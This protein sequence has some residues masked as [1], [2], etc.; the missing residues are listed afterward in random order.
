MEPKLFLLAVTFGKENLC[1]D[2]NGEI[3]DYSNSHLLKSQ[4]CH[5]Q[6]RRQWR[7][8]TVCGVFLFVYENPILFVE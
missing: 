6:D 2:G 1:V 8:H 5:S 3:K 7:G 4:Y